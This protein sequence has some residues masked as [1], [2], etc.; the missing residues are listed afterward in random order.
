MT[1]EGLAL[2]ALTELFLCLSPGPAVL[3]VVGTS[4]RQGP[5]AGLMT[6]LGILAAN[7]FYFALSA[8]G[9]G[10]LILASHALFTLLKWIGAAYL[11][12]LGLGMA[13]PL[14]EKLRGS[15]APRSSDA[16][17]TSAHAAPAAAE[18]ARR[19]IWRG[20]ALQAANPKNLAFFVAILPQFLVP[21]DGVSL[22]LLTLGAIS[23]LLELPILVAYGAAASWGARAMS[24]ARLAWIEGAAGGL[25]IAAAAGLLT[26]KG[27]D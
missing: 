8:L 16:A 3:L 5:R 23:L 24:S 1:W 13:R 4:A 19:T 26:L 25:L 7:V 14:L 21:G 22:Q 9:I 20:F 15:R 18:P 6:T 11:V 10:A 17:E 2:F 12:W 27:D